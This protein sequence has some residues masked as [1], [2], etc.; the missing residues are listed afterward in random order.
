MEQILYYI[1]YALLLVFGIAVS[2]A[3]SGIGL[4]KR[5]LIR[6][7]LLTALCGGLQIAVYG[8][9]GEAAVWR[10]YPLITHLPI[11]LALRFLFDRYL[12]NAISATASAYLCCQPAKWFSLAAFA[13]SR[14]TRTE[15][16]VRILM[17][18]IT[19]VVVLRYFSPKI[20][21][22]YSHRNKSSWVFGTIPVVYYLFDYTVAIYSSLWA[23]NH[24]LVVEFL[25]F[26][27]CAGHLLFCAVY[28]REYELKHEAEQ[29]EQL[30]RITVEQQAKEVEMIHR[31]EAEIRCLRHDLQLFLNAL[32]SCIEQSDRETAQKMISGFSQRAAA[33]S[34]KRYCGND[35]LNYVLSD[36][37]AQCREKGVRFHSVIELDQLTVDEI[38]FSTI[39][40]NALDNALNA[41][42]GPPAPG[43]PQGG[44]RLLLKRSN[45]KILLCVKN[46]FR[47]TPQFQ[48]GYPATSRKGHGHGVQ[49]ILYITEKLGGNCQFT[50]ED[51]WFVLRVVI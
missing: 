27:L 46:T 25:P 42:E 26:F 15:L 37:A 44:I 23:D 1:L 31:S 2:A 36:Y 24:Q 4:N 13:V 18:L 49:S 51:N 35:T 3:F 17:L 33:S 22:I 47:Q 8:V 11:I 43:D 14:N 39:L 38:L 29:K 41:Q 45:D 21:R 19:A 9:F 6:M 32:S 7:L 16:L 50:L 5:N 34:V 48:D 28:Y 12:S 30:L 20:A 40:V 10:W